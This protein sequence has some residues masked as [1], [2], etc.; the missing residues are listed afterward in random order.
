MVDQVD[1]DDS[2]EGNRVV[3][4]DGEDIGIVS[5]VRS[6]TVYVDPNPGLAEALMSKLGWEDIDEDDYPLPADSIERITDDE[7]HLK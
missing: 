6:G 5:G 2:L 1:I 7:L 4:A 3:D